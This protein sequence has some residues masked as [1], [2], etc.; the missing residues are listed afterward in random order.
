MGPVRQYTDEPVDA[1]TELIVYPGVNGTA[2]WYDDDGHSFDYRK[3][4]FMRIAMQWSD[5]ERRLSMRLAPGSKM[6]DNGRRIAV[7]IAGG[8][9]AKESVFAGKA[10][11]VSL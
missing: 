9:A 10:L 2:S 5:R 3:G 7:R 11:T 4:A 8:S 6:L 1:P